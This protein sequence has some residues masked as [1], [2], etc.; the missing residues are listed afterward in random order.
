M[1]KAVHPLSCPFPMSKG[2]HPLSTPL[3]SSRFSFQKKLDLGM[4]PAFLG[5]QDQVWAGQGASSDRTCCQCRSFMPGL[6]EMLRIGMC[7]LNLSIFILTFSANRLGAGMSAK[8]LVNLYIVLHIFPISSAI[9]SAFSKKR[10]P[11][12]KKMNGGKGQTPKQ[13]S[14]TCPFNSLSSDW[15]CGVGIGSKHR[16]ELGLC[17][18]C[19]LC[20]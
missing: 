17:M 5:L 6:Q 4:V 9:S 16:L 7:C 10:G 18:K 14:A 13:M 8:V 2:P 3:A 1:R 19:R 20:Q 11:G 15:A 12:I